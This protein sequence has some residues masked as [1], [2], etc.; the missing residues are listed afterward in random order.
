MRVAIFITIFLIAALFLWRFIDKGKE[1]ETAPSATTEPVSNVTTKSE[2]NKSA[3]V[4]ELPKP[5]EQPHPSQV[6][7]RYSEPPRQQPGPQIP[8]PP[9]NPPFPEAYYPPRPPRPPWIKYEKRVNRLVKAREIEDFVKKVRSKNIAPYVGVGAPYF[10]SNPGTPNSNPLT[11]DDPKPVGLDKLVGSYDGEIRFDDGKKVWQMLLDLSG[12]IEE[13]KLK[14]EAT[15]DLSESGTTISKTTQKGEL[16]LLKK[17][18]DGSVGI[19][20]APTD[21]HFFQLYYLPERDMLA[22]NYY[23]KKA[24]GQIVPVGTVQLSRKPAN[25]H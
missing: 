17:V 12:R 25:P 21:T 4:S 24:P 6:P 7:G 22:G 5:T 2:L 11:P 10:P 23:E 13:Q 1:E 14:G 19:L 8:P 18:A 20:V 3:G 15:V 9:E 16:T